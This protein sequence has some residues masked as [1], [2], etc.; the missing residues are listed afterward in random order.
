MYFYTNSPHVFKNSK[1]GFLNSKIITIPDKFCE[2]YYLP[3]NVANCEHL[4]DILNEDKNIDLKLASK[5]CE[6]YLDSS[7]HFQKNAS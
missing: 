7:N 5:L 6:E 4:K 2:K 1:A 3:S